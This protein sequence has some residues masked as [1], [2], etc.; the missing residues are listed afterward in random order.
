MQVQDRNPLLQPLEK[1]LKVKAVHN[2][3]SDVHADTQAELPYDGFNNL[4]GI[5][6]GLD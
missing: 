1:F 3:V 2:E 5:I 6:Q 4:E